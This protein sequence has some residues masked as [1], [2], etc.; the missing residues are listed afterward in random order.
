M[1]K[2]TDNELMIIKEV[3]NKL[4]IPFRNFSDI[5]ED[6]LAKFLD[7]HWNSCEESSG[8]DGPDASEHLAGFF[9]NIIRD[10][11]SCMG[12]VSCWTLIG[13]DSKGRYIGVVRK[14]SDEN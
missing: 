14:D 2:L 13:G 12:D 3:E 4:G 8:F 5:K 1:V 7:V 9:S 10:G 11:I 6:S